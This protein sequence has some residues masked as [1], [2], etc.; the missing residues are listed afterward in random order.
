MKEFLL[1]FA[2]LYKNCVDL[3]QMPSYAASELDVDVFPVLG[4]ISCPIQSSIQDQISSDFQV[5]CLI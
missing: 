2:F 4:P 1:Y 3:D 5:A